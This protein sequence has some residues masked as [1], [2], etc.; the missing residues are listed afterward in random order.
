MCYHVP[1]SAAADPKET[2]YTSERDLLHEQMRT[3][4][5]NY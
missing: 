4:R 3:T 5:G 1:L 2:Y